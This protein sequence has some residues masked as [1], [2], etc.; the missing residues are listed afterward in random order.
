MNLEGAPK[1]SR[2]VAAERI[3]ELPADLE[4]EEEESDPECPS[5][6]SDSEDEEQDTGTGEFRC[7]KVGDHVV[8]H[9]RKWAFYF[10]TISD[11]DKSK[12]EYN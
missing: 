6:E 9:H 4:E 10:A 1:R 11:Y 12:M 2:G 3:S 7:P 5:Y 8:S